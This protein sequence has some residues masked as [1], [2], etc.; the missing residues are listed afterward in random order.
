MLQ[1]LIVIKVRPHHAWAAE[2]VPSEFLPKLRAVFVGAARDKLS[3]PTKLFASHTEFFKL[4]ANANLLHAFAESTR[5]RAVRITRVG[6]YV[7]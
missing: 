7:G 3:C 1:F 5:G 6:E 4:V 2:R